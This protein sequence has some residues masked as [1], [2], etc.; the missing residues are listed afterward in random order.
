MVIVPSSFQQSPGQGVHSISPADRDSLPT[1]P[2]PTPITWSSESARQVVQSP[3]DTQGS[4]NSSITPA[5]LLRNS[6]VSP[7]N[8]NVRN[9]SSVSAPTDRSEQ[10]LSPPTL[11]QDMSTQYEISRPP[12]SQVLSYP[13]PS[14]TNLLGSGIGSLSSLAFDSHSVSQPTSFLRQT[15][16]A[17]TEASARSP[18]EDKEQTHPAKRLRRSSYTLPAGVATGHNPISSQAECSTGTEDNHLSSVTQNLR[19]VPV[20]SLLS[21]S[22]ELVP[23][24]ARPGYAADDKQQQ[25]HLDSENVN[26]GLDCGYPDYDLNKNDDFG[27]IE[28]IS[29][30]D[31]IIRDSQSSPTSTDAATGSQMPRRKPVF[32]AGGYYASPVEINIPRHL[33]PLPST[34]RENPINLMYF[35]HFLNHTARILV[36]HDCEENPFISV[37]PSSK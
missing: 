27:A 25:G 37:L 35:H 8:G 29:S 4:H 22:T 19:R 15:F 11:L 24:E 16:P 17:A 21:H 34:L 9:Y 30:L 2:V 18:I 36:P 10:A 12:T 26:F 5:S 13:S 7:G 28:N 14:D 3:Q 6:P 33:T 1:F 32:T 23:E 20:T 31:V